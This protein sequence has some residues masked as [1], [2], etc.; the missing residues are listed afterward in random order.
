MASEGEY[1][2]AVG[3]IGSET[4]SQHGRKYFGKIM[5]RLYRRQG[6]ICIG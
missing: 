2:S 3:R 4:A 1:L 6:T 5:A